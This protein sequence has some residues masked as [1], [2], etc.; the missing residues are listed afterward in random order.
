MHSTK[1]LVAGIFQKKRLS[2]YRAGKR[3]QEGSQSANQHPPKK[4][5]HQEVFEQSTPRGI[6]MRLQRPQG[7]GLPHRVFHSGQIRTVLQDSLTARKK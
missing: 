4:N 1:T 7:D 5:C 3:M 6:A 2:K